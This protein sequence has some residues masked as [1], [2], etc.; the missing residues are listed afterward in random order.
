MSTMTMPTKAIDGQSLGFARCSELNQAD[1]FRTKRSFWLMLV[2]L[3]LMGF[4]VNL[5]RSP[6]LNPNIS[7]KQ[8]RPCPPDWPV[9]T[10]CKSSS[11]QLRPQKDERFLIP[12]QRRQH[13]GHGADL[14]ESVCVCVCLANGD[15][16]FPPARNCQLISRRPGSNVITS[17]TPDFIHGLHLPTSPRWKRKGSP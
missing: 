5:R 9:R 4:A 11:S 13:D 2:K 14:S 10:S 1:E 3:G 17:V 7:A 6:P 8:K 15:W 12:S 16:C